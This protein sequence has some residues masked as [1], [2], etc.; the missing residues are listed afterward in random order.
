MTDDLSAVPV[1]A[2]A[3]SPTTPDDI[4]AENKR[5]R[6]ENEKL[7]KN[8][9]AARLHQAGRVGRSSLVVFLLL[10]ATVLAL[11]TPP[12]V[13][14][15]NQLLNTD[16]YV[17][18]LAPLA[19]NPGV[20]DGVIKAVDQQIDSHL[21]L[22]GLLAETLP[23]RAAPLAGPI[24]SALE[25]FANAIVTR[26]VQSPAFQTLWT[27]M[28]RL[29]HTQIVAI[30]TGKHPANQ[31]VDVHNGVVQLDLS[32]V[33]TE[34]KQRL[35]AAG[36]PVASK[37]PPIGATIDIAQVKGLD[38]A[39]HA[40]RLLN[41]AAVWLPWLTLFFFAAAIAA[42][43]RRRQRL[44]TSAICLAGAMVVLRLAIAVGRASYLHALPGV[45]LTHDASGS[46]FDTVLRFLVD[47]IR[48]VFIVALLVI[49]VAAL[50]G[51]SR[52]AVRTRATL[53]GAPSWLGS[54]LPETAFGR[55][56]ARWRGPLTWSILGIAALVVLLWGQL[57]IALIVTVGIVALL[58]VLL[59]RALGADRTHSSA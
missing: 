8:R 26:F 43:R 52:P 16:R 12:V 35:V 9:S 42:S 30:L 10:I 58:A 54:R 13:W 37:I 36:L 15:R 2:A 4:S 32:A 20:Q 48:I 33:V 34:V 28:N 11:L 50:F 21:D 53:R 55:A 22:S 17:A 46:V 39:Q 49:L 24:K 47:G 31:T 18:T 23:P 57:S 6:A 59:V 29:A 19:A 44:I 27:E 1:P 45:Y 38:K 40:V 41:S 3:S 14:S 25:G 51:P 5:L 7:R 56:V